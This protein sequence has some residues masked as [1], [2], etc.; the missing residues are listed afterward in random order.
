MGKRLAKQKLGQRGHKQEPAVPKY[1]ACFIFCC[2]YENKTAEILNEISS[3][4]VSK[5][6]NMEQMRIYDLIYS[7]FISFLCSYLI[8][9]P[10]L[11]MKNRSSVTAFK[12]LIL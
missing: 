7:A 1:K 2:L 9:L 10:M 4:Y 6:P 12:I 5:V 8:T 3:S 11:H